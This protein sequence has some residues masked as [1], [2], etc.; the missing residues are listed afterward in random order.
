M[1]QTPETTP[2]QSGQTAPLDTTAQPQSGSLALIRERLAGAQ[3]Y[4]FTTARRVSHDALGVEFC[5]VPMKRADFEAWRNLRYFENQKHLGPN[6]EPNEA[7]LNR[8]MSAKHL[9]QHAVYSKL[10]EPLGAEDAQALM[11][12]AGLWPGTQTVLSAAEHQNPPRENLSYEV[13]MLWRKNQSEIAVWQ[14][15]FECGLGRALLDWMAPSATA[16][17]QEQARHNIVKAEEA[18]H[19]FSAFFDAREAAQ[20]LGIKLKNAP[21]VLAEGSQGAG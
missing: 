19:G 14:V 1:N 4:D 13:Q 9:L 21:Q 2:P 12:G 6:G 15:L 18:L 11:S 20:I 8:E 3:S 5:V 17:E 16:E 10:G 7:P